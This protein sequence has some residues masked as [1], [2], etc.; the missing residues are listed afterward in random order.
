MCF[1]YF[2]Q[3]SV[4]YTNDEHELPEIQVFREGYLPFEREDKDPLEGINF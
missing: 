3:E 2:C 4:I 1:P